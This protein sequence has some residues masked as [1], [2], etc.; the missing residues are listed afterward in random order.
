MWSGLSSGPEGSGSN[1]GGPLYCLDGRGNSW[2]AASLV[3]RLWE[4][5]CGVV[6]MVDEVEVCVRG[7]KGGVSRAGS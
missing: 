1:Q 7:T 4:V 5:K 2:W 6:G 3:Q